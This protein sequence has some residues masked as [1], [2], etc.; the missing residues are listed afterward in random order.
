M[1]CGSFSNAPAPNSPHSTP[2]DRYLLPTRGGRPQCTTRTAAHEIKVIL[3]PQPAFHH[4]LSHCVHR[5]RCPRQ[6]LRRG[7]IVES[8]RFHLSQPET[9]SGSGRY[10]E[11]RNS[12]IE[13]QDREAASV[14]RLTMILSRGKRVGGSRE[15]RAD[16][17]A[18]SQRGVHMPRAASRQP[19][20]TT[21]IQLPI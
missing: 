1:T 13:D 19:R 17:G 7:S 11:S 18:D 2:V 12:E 5:L 3:L 8:G 4:R 16:A 6:T 20:H 21:A 15:R 9:R 14:P 10:N